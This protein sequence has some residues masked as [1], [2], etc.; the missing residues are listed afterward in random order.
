[1][2]EDSEKKDKP[3]PRRV[4]CRKTL[5]AGKKYRIRVFLCKDAAGKKRYHGETFHGTAGQAEDRIR[6]IIR[7]H[8]TGE[9]IKATSDT[10]GSFL[11]VWL[12]SKKLA[13]AESSYETYRYT[14]E[15]HIRPA[16]GKKMLITV[17][18]EDI[19]RFY[20][21]LHADKISRS[22]IRYVHVVLGMVFT[23]AVK[24]KKLMGSPMTAVDIPKEETDNQDAGAE[25]MD[26]RQVA[27][28]LEAAAGAR[29]PNLFKL[30]FHVGFRPSELL[31]LKWDDF[32]QE[33]KMLRV[34]QNLVWRKAPELK[35][36]P[37][38]SRWYLKAP[39]TRSSGRT[40]PLTDAMVDLLKTQK[41]SQL[42]DRLRAGKL[43]EDHGFIFCD[44]AGSPWA[45]HQVYHDFKRALKTAGLPSHFSPYST[46]HTM[47]SNL[48]SAGVNPKAVQTR[49]GHKRIQTT[50]DEYGHVLPGEQEAISEKIERLLKGQK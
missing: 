41:R 3:E 6:E 27:K 25:A 5:V 21:K 8:R 22:Y 33:E 23:L 26:A 14:I 11:D 32:N 12:E 42:E 17:T 47:A 1:V 43:W 30:A 19:Q 29:F 10:F 49:L 20:V 7:R 9:A 4:G 36:N 40:L 45:L 24:R 18:A 50:L 48:L 46:R 15:K 39:K 35:A 16:L 44:T 2:A 37:N 38:L 13:V 34:D 28:F 31:A